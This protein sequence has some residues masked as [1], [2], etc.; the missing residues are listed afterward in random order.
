[1]QAWRERRELYLL[2]LPPEKIVEIEHTPEDPAD[3]SAMGR[4]PGRR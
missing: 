1:V 3:G 2:R 4:E